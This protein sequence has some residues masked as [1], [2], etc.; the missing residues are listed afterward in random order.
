MTMLGQFDE[1]GAYFAE[2]K[3][4]PMDARRLQA[5]MFM[6]RPDLWRRP[7]KKVKPIPDDQLPLL[8]AEPEN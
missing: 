8:P 2:H 5:G 1:Q 3:P 6:D 7:P 4:K